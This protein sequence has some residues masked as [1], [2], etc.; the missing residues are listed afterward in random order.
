MPNGTDKKIIGIDTLFGNSGVVGFPNNHDKRII[1]SKNDIFDHNNV[2]KRDIIETKWMP[3]LDANQ[4]AFRIDLA[5]YFKI[6]S[7][8]CKN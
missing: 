2:I 1:E 4:N 6:N 3:F 8:K 5:E 7:F